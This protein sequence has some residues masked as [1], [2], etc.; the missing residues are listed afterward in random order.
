[1]ENTKTA[2]G[3]TPCYCEHCARTSAIIDGDTAPGK[4]AAGGN[5]FNLFTLRIA[6][7]SIF[8]VLGLLLE[9]QIIPS[10]IISFHQTFFQNFS[11]SVSP[12]LIVCIA[13]YILIGYDVV[14]RSI[15]NISRGQ[16]FDENFLMTIATFGAFAIKAYPEAVAVMLFY[17][18]GEAFQ[19]G[20]VRRSRTSI[21]AL[22]DIR[23]D[24]AN[25]K[26]NGEIRAV[27]PN[28][29]SVGSII[30]VKPGEKIPLD[31]VIV[32]GAS[33]IDT[34]A[35][36]GESMP[37]DV[38][39]GC[40]VLSGT[41][42]KSGL[43]T[44]K[45]TKSAGES[46]VARILEMVQ[47]AAQKKSKVEKF[48]T[49]FARY[50]T[51]VV[52]IAALLLA[53]VPPIVSG[54]MDFS[55]WL[56]RALVF[57]VV[58]CPCALVISVPLSFF[59]G[60][61]GASKQ[62]I[63][64][65]GSSYLEALSNID[66]I[67]FD[68]TGTLT[69]G[70]FKI[71]GIDTAGTYSK[72]EVLFYAA[73][74]EYFSKHPIAA[75]ITSAFPDKVDTSIIEGLEEIAGRGVRANIN[76][77]KVLA[78]NK[79][80]LENGNV[81]FMSYTGTGVCVYIAIDNKYAGRIIIKD[82][83]KPD[84]AATIAALKKLGVRQTTMFTGD[85]EMEGSLVAGQIGID[86]PVTGLLPDEKVEAFEKIAGLRKSKG[87]LV[88]VGDGINDAPVLARS[89]VGIAMGARGTDA[90]IEAAD[91]VLMTDEPAKICAAVAIARKTHRIV[92]QNIVF[93]LGVK[94][95]ILGAG[96]LGAASIWLAVF[97]DVGVCLIAVMNAM[98]AARYKGLKI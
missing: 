59:G 69:K 13:A 22:M 4:S 15:K 73:H 18:I 75:A 11:L 14:L 8:F 47:N 93:A 26:E 9:A 84:S 1:M 89:D 45:V 83:I 41:I 85:T 90:A 60:I 39:A 21:A 36:T 80:L 74:T 50:Y 88:F 92:K 46:T 71:A 34:S 2:P 12:A 94:G 67:V 33:S 49:K 54:N 95:V 97:G 37:R 82:E 10:G 20:A 57:L 72:D 17:Q 40:E 28:D 52:V 98:R 16:I 96:A 66:T 53:L 55:R 70:I 43:L 35:L 77:K 79:K 44:V 61:G 3:M 38:E 48:I 51:P 56:Y 64:I 62:G 27:S 81:E 30:I 58:S 5:F 42:N 19:D 65:K 78:G 68:K 23:P 25:L 31:G 6:A 7:G 24:Y 76:G 86:T 63:L 29:V 91:V 32:E 87:S